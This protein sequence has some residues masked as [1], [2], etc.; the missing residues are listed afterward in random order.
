MQH[1]TITLTPGLK[2]VAPALPILGEIPRPELEVWIEAAIQIL[3]AYDGDPD[4]EGQSTE[5]EIS[6][7]SPFTT[8]GSGDGAGCS[9][10]DPGGCQHDGREPEEGGLCIQYGEDQ[11]LLPKSLR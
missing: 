9:V 6:C 7:F 11:R 4:L 5:D 3:D 10:A 8:M 1:E 2:P